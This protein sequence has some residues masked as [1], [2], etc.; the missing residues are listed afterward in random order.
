MAFEKWYILV[1][2]ARNKRM[3]KNKPPQYV[4]E[5]KYRRTDADQ[6]DADSFICVYYLFMNGK[7]RS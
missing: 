1:P 4:I 7:I 5:P 3:L 6:I 2:K